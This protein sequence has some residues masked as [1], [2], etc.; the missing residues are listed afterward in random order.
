MNKLKG[1]REDEKEKK[2]MLNLE[3]TI[4]KKEIV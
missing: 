4:I 2:N 3:L 1:D